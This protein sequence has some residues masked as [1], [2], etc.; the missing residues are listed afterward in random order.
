MSNI[1]Q[2]GSKAMLDWI[3]GGASPT[4]PATYGVGLS[5]GSPTSVSGSEVGTASGY[6]VQ[7]VSFCA[8]STPT[9][10]GTVTNQNAMT[11][12]PFSTAQSISGLIVK[13]TLA[14]AG[15]LLWYGTLTSAR[16]VS[17]GDS[18]V[19]AAGALTITLS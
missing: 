7:T 4:R 1:A 5:L 9:G 17:I 2:Y 3:S 13:D 16:T 14:T 19:I 10:S 18:L 12:G 8:A 6:T 15:N 11:F